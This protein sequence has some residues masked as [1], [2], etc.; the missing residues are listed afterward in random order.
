MIHFFSDRRAAFSASPP[1]PHALHTRLI[2]ILPY[3]PAIGCGG[4]LKRERKLAA[5]SPPPLLLCGGQV[6]WAGKSATPHT[7]PAPSINQ[8]ENTAY[9]YRLAISLYAFTLQPGPLAAAAAA[10][11]LPTVPNPPIYSRSRVE[12]WYCRI[13][14]CCGRFQSP[15]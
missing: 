1:S 3:T 14:L 5:A 9:P 13:L 2:L 10:A 12:E 11:L 8:N 7:V 4:G 15:Q 6:R